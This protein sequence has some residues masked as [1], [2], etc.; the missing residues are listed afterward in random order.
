MPQPRADLL[1]CKTVLE[2]ICAGMRIVKPTEFIADF[3]RV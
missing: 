1:G 2:V 3:E